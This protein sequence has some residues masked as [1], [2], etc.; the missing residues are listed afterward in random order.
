[1]EWQGKAETLPGNKRRGK[2][3]RTHRLLSTHKTRSYTVPEHASGIQ[4]VC[5]EHA[6][7][8]P[9]PTL[10]DQTKE[11]GRGEGNEAYFIAF[12]KAAAP[13]QIPN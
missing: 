6:W 10:P 13:P 5:R 2:P 1:M 11:R 7:L 8:Q 9:Y 4:K 12:L 3:D